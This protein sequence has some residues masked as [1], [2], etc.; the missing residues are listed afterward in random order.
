MVMVDL[1]SLVPL[2]SL[3][4]SLFYRLLVLD[5]LSIS[6]SVV[7]FYVVVKEFFGQFNDFCHRKL[8]ISIRLNVG[9]TRGIIFCFVQWIN[10]IGKC[11]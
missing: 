6:S 7:E 2:S 9:S 8:E 11:I 5:K 10:F 1:G 4:K 3:I